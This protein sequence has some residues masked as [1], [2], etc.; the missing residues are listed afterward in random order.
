MAKTYPGLPVVSESLKVR[1]WGSAKEEARPMPQVRQDK[2]SFNRSRH[3]LN[4]SSGYGRVC[5]MKSSL[6]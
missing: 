1:Q 5:R 6:E 4:E 2:P 3:S